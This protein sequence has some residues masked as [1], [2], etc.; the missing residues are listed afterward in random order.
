M[1]ALLSA[2]FN[3]QELALLYRV[4]CCTCLSYSGGVAE[5]LQ[6]DTCGPLNLATR[7]EELP[8]PFELF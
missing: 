5:A 3:E 2:S 6:Q 8:P 7:K 1:Q 4:K